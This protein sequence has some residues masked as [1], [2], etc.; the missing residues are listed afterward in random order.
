MNSFLSRA[1]K[2]I[3]RTQ[4]ADWKDAGVALN[5]EEL[6]GCQMPAGPGKVE[7]GSRNVA[8]QYNEVMFI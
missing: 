6:I 7:D 8:L 4:P 1:T 2:G 3:G 5:N